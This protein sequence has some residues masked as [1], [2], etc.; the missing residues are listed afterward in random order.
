M[1]K[2]A[3]LSDDQRAAVVWRLAGW[4]EQTPEIKSMRERARRIAIETDTSFSSQ[5]LSDA[6]KGQLGRDVLATLERYFGESH[7]T[8]MKAAPVATL[9]PAAT[10]APARQ[11]GERY[12]ERELRYPGMRVPFLRARAAGVSDRVLDTVAARIGVWRDQKGPSEKEVERLIEDEV[13]QT[14]KARKLYGAE[15]MDAE[16]KR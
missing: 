9:A 1:A 4:A 3:E 13:N 6:M 7:K 14:R 10:T 11:P 8:W 15:D 2:G 12:Y 5:A 16:L